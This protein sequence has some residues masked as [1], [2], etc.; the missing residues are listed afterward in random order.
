MVALVV[1]VVLGF[2]CSSAPSESTPTPSP[3]QSAATSA[4]EQ[5]AP[6][7]TEEAARPPNIVLIIGDDHG[8]PYFGFMGNEIVHTPN[9]DRL[10]GEGT[11]F[12]TAYATASKC[13]PSLR[14]LLTGREA[15]PRG[16]RTAGAVGRVQRVRS[17]ETLPALLA[18]QGYA[19]FQAGK[20]W[21]PSYR[22][23]GFDEGTKGENLT[24]SPT[25]RWMGGAE[26]LRVGRDTMRPL[27]DFIDRHR[28][29]QFFVWFAP[30]LPHRPWNAPKRFRVLYEKS[31]IELTPSAIGYYANISW[32][33]HALG[34]LRSHL[35]RRGLLANTLLVYLSDN[36]FRQEPGDTFTQ[37]GSTL[38]K[39]TMYDLGFRT[40]LVFHWKGR[41]PA[42]VVRTDLVSALDLFP[43]LLDYAGAPVPADLIGL[44][45][46]PAIE[47]GVPLARS[48]IIGR[49]E[50]A[51]PHFEDQ[52]SAK[53]GSTS[54][55]FLRE[56]RWHYVWYPD[57]GDDQLFDLEVD[58]GE[59]RNVIRDHPDVAKDLRERIE[60]WRANPPTTGG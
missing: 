52:G 19:T 33:D 13:E 35:E 39:G 21:Q 42:G 9:L 36:G 32:F 28:A 15:F 10:A 56:A 18:K 1:L 4:S 55:Y 30:M 29:T 16:P 43:T 25:D 44:D 47:K 49:M 45:L 26:G 57:V 46:R 8:Y 24:G 11:V 20:L 7:S 31:A 58:A 12:T 60:R 17:A 40:P 37:E 59:T 14:S 54:A 6:L 41:V 3:S 22:A 27:L 34:V 48:E 53:A 51:R 38:S 23:A 50:Q 2:G 5:A